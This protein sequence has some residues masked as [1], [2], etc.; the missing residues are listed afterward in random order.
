MATVITHALVAGAISV[1]SPSEASSYGEK[2]SKVPRFRLIVSMVLLAVIPD[3]DSLAFRYGIPYEDVFGHRG[4]T[5]SL[6]F[7]IGLAFVTG[8]LLFRAIGIGSKVWCYIVFLLCLAGVSHG[9]IDAFTD[10]G[11]GVGFLIP[12]D[13]DR[14]FFPWRPIDTS[15]VSIRA[16]FNGPAQTILLNE[17]VWVL[18]PV[19]TV[20]A[21]V[22]ISRFLI[23]YFLGK[24]RK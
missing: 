5:H 9:I 10:A 7:S 23:K 18:L 12:F 11:L 2:F 13:L 21:F 20:T 14:Y 6:I 15:P 24:V 4:F 17:F 19:Y 16:F 22:S 8:L 1:L 3:V